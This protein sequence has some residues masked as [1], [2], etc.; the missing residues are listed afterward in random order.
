MLLISQH[1]LVVE[2]TCGQGPHD[3]DPSLEKIIFSSFQLR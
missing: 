3:R 2:V 1:L